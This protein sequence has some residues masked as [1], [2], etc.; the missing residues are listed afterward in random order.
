[1]VYKRQLRDGTG[2][3]VTF[4]RYLKASGEAIHL[5]GVEPEVPVEVEQPEL[6]EPL[7][8]ED[9]ILEKAVEQIEESLAAT[10]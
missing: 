7:P 10:A 8:A 1:M 4:V 5:S 9:R 6:G 3:W 2:L